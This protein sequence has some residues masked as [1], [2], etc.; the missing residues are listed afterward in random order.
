MYKYTVMTNWA[1]SETRHPQIADDHNIGGWEDITGQPIPN[2]LPD[3][4]IYMIYGECELAVLDAIEAD[5]NY[6]VVS[7]EEIVEEIL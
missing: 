1:V 3:P 2:I 7:S 5:P 6:F 4:N